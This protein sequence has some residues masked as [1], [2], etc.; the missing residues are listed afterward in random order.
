L[1]DTVT[2]GVNLLGEGDQPAFSWA[3][4][5]QL[6]SIPYDPAK[7]RALLDTAG[8]KPGPDGVRLKNGQ[9]LHVEIATTIGNAIG[10]R[11]AVLLQSA[12]HD[13]GVDAEVRPYVAS[14]MF[15]TYQ[16]GGILQGGKYDVQFSSWVN[17]VDPDD[18][19]NFSCSAFPP[20][21]QNTYRFCSRELDA[22]EGIAM[23]SF[24]Q[25][26]R[27][28]A[29]ARIQAILVDQVPLVT[30]WFQRRVD[31][32]NDDLTGYKPAKAVTPFWNTWEYA[33]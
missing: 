12:W 30:M 22:Q 7:A 6:P 26:T 3:H 28:R 24:D 21:G 20:H 2:F 17:G 4:D 14:L 15:A 27:K 23:T 31:V 8:W 16:S 32:V 13:I 29:Y 5:P 25:S 19:T 9:R 18:S 11:L 1:I 33:I 10:N